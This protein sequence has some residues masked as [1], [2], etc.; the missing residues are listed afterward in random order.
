MLEMSR[1]R[2]YNTSSPERW[3]VFS[4]SIVEI[5][6]SHDVSAEYR[7][8]RSVALGERIAVLEGLDHAPVTDFV[9]GLNGTAE[10]LWLLGRNITY[11]E[12]TVLGPYVLRV[13]DQGI[14]GELEAPGDRPFR[15]VIKVI[16]IS[17]PAMTILQRRYRV[18]CSG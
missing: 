17:L 1:L 4:G 14:F 9:L 6:W 12:D 18:S 2:L 5:F 8:N 3:F 11:I 15:G 16:D 10:R 7:W 13:E